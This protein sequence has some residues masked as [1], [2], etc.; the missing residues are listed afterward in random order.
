[1][2]F[3]NL[4]IFFRIFQGIRQFLFECIRVLVPYQFFQFVPF[5]SD[6]FLG[7]C[8]FF[9][10]LVPSLFFLLPLIFKVFG[11][12]LFGSQCR[13]G[14]R[15]TGF[16]FPQLL[17]GLFLIVLLLSFHS[18]LL[19]P[20]CLC[21]FKSKMIRFQFLLYLTEC[22][23]HGRHH[24]CQAFFIGFPIDVLLCYIPPFGGILGYLLPKRIQASSQRLQLS[25]IPVQL[26]LKPFLLL[27]LL[28]QF[29][30][31]SSNLLIHIRNEGFVFLVLQERMIAGATKRTGFSLHQGLTLHFPI[32][33]SYKC[34]CLF[35]NFQFFVLGNY[36]KLTTFY[37][38]RFVAFGTC[39]Y[40]RFIP[41]P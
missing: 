38:N 39:L 6:M 29:V 15:H 12:A 5:P 23:F 30:L 7:I 1:M 36:I 3:L 13:Y 35:K 31:F 32:T 40:L 9:D 41:C 4:Y 8:L 20:K 34:I 17:F 24:R 28:C 26:L 25:P 10:R 27:Y 21:L 14:I 33:T 11:F 37:F 22:I 19:S 16:Q 2:L 18:F